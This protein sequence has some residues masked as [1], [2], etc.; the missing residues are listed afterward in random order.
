MEAGAAFLQVTSATG[1]V[2]KGWMEMHTEELKKIGERIK[3]MR[4]ILPK[5]V[6]DMASSLGMS[7]DEYRGCEAGE[8]DFAF[9]FL[10]NCAKIFEINYSELLTGEA[11]RLHK[12]CV[13]R[14]NEGLDLKRRAG[15]AY[16]NLAY[17]FQGRVAEPFLVEA[18]EADGGEEIA[19]SA[20]AGQEMD[21]VLT[22]SLK[23]VVDGKVELLHAGDAIYYDSGYRH[24]MVAA[25]P[26]GSTFLAFVMQE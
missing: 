26:D 4:E 14:A 16:Q 5:T 7:E 1:A 22:G 11:P 20:H 18:P 12:Y 8:T 21:Y 13:V 24:G 23:V 25:S 9:T 3:C 2:R 17:Q 15:F 6:A 10:Y 19:L